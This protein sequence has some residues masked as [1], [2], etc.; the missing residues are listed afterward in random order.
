M[1][2]IWSLQLPA[3]I[4]D[5]NGKIH[6]KKYNG[7]NIALSPSPADKI[8]VEA[9]SKSSHLECLQGMEP[10]SP[11]GPEAGHGFHGYDDDTDDGGYIPCAAAV[12]NPE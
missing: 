11:M 8:E 3:P 1:A 12:V 5:S 2:W 9:A 6:L 4:L 7:G 10:V